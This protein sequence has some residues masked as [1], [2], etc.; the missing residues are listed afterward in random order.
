MFEHEFTHSFIKHSIVGEFDKN[1]VV[2]CDIDDIYKL[3]LSQ[4]RQVS[5]LVSR[6]A[7]KLIFKKIDFLEYKLKND[8]NDLV[9]STIGLDKKLKDRY[10]RESL[11]YIEFLESLI[12]NVIDAEVKEYLDREKTLIGG[13]SDE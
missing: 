13:V 10:T 9:L 5:L 11:W 8:F 7:R 12:E 4:A 1:E 3:T 2:Y 6:M